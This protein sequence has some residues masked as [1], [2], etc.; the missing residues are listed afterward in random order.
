MVKFTN[1]I[2]VDAPTLNVN[3]TGA[4]AIHRKGKSVGSSYFKANGVY[5]FVYDGTQWN[6]VTTP[7]DVYEVVAA[8]SPTTTYQAEGDY[9]FETLS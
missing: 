5:E 6:L 7:G 4:K 8:S 2:T 3:S 1:T 9:W